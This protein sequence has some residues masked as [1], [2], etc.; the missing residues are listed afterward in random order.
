MITKNSIVNKSKFLQYASAP[1]GVLESQGR[2]LSA[3]LGGE[4]ADLMLF[5]LFEFKLL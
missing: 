1:H 5:D 2:Q 4:L 3:V